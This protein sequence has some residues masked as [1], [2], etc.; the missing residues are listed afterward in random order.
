MRP[1]S[2]T[3]LFPNQPQQFLV[4][5]NYSDGSSQ[6][7]QTFSYGLPNQ[8]QYY[9]RAV[10][11]RIGQNSYCQLAVLTIQFL[12]KWNRRV[13]L[14]GMLPAGVNSPAYWFSPYVGLTFRG[15]ATPPSLVELLG[16]VS[17]KGRG[18]S[19]R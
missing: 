9:V 17:K 5:G 18:T 6:N 3:V 19:L 12:K 13:L 16:P 11:R 14:A 15:S 1:P 4:M 2:N 8:R 10:L 7:N